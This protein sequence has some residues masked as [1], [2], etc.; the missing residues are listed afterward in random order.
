M[1]PLAQ[2]KSCITTFYAIEVRASKT[3]IVYRSIYSVWLSCLIQCHFTD[4][5]LPFCIERTGFLISLLRLR[6]H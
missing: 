3:R 6:K 1:T 4:N 2:A 5:E